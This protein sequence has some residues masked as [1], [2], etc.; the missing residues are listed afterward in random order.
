ME[1][2]NNDSFGEKIKKIEDAVDTMD[3]REI[4]VVKPEKKH[5]EIESSSN[6]SRKSLVSSVVLLTVFSVVLATA[7]YMVFLSNPS[8]TEVSVDSP[9]LSLETRS[10]SSDSWDFYE[11]IPLDLG[12]VYGTETVCWEFRVTKNAMDNSYYSDKDHYDTGFDGSQIVGEFQAVLSDGDGVVGLDELD[13]IVV[14]ITGPDVAVETLVWSNDGDSGNDDFVPV[15]VVDGGVR[16]VYPTVILHDQWGYQGSVC[17]IFDQ[18][19]DGDYSVSMQ[20]I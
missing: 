12:S 10:N 8:E 7:G 1:E 9:L 3:N 19:A 4:E 15:D 5:D 16:V 2:K 13:S 17:L 18:Y 14:D 11:S 20:V 6:V